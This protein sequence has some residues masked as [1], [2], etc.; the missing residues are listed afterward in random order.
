MP[1]SSFCCS[2][3]KLTP[4]VRTQL[5]LIVA[6]SSKTANAQGAIFPKR[7]MKIPLT[8]TAAIQKAFRARRQSLNIQP[9]DSS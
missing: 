5:A 1:L 8:D 9:S 2:S 3:I 6:G 4:G 7:E